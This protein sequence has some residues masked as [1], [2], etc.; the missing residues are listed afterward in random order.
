MENHY[1][2]SQIG[3]ALADVRRVQAEVEEEI[4]TVNRLLWRIQEE[5]EHAGTRSAVRPYSEIEA[6]EE[7]ARAL[8]RGLRSKRS[9]CERK[10]N[11]LEE[12]RRELQL[13]AARARR[14]ALAEQNARKARK[15]KVSG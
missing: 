15:R 11:E 8:L 4:V 1:T 10:I 2:L 7:S 13:A 5:G 12:A 9:C 6:D 3:E 14:A